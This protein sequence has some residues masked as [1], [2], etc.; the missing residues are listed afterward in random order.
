M[1]G[2]LED[3]IEWWTARRKSALVVEII[4]GKTTEAEASRALD[5]VPSEIET[6]VDDARNGMENVLCGNPL[7]RFAEGL[8]RVLCNNAA[9]RLEVSAF[10]V[11]P[12]LERNPT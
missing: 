12:V 5:S 11:K 6:R 10:F 9:E 7:Q 2:Q 8:N 3:R 4:E 1:S